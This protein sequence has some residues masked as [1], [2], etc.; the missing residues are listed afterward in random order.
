MNQDFFISY[1]YFRLFKVICMK[2]PNGY[3]QS[4]LLENQSVPISSQTLY[5]CTRL[6]VQKAVKSI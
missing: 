3:Q 6:K 4:G 5:K 2:K 1:F